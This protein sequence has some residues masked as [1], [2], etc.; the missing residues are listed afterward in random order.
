MGMAADFYKE[1]GENRP[2]LQKELPQVMAAVTSM[3]HETYKDGALSRSFKELLALAISISVRCDSCII[4]HT[5]NA[6]EAGA[7]KEEV[8]ETLAV[9]MQMCGGP[10][11]VEGYRLVQILEELTS[12]GA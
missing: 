2:K 9:A 7:T 1:R 11:I 4:S 10:A 6:L 12:A 5:H 8:M 3:V